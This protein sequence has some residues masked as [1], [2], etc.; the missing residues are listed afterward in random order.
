MQ[1]GELAGA[2]TESPGIAQA[3]KVQVAMEEEGAWK[4]YS[5]IQQK[6]KAD[7][8]DVY[9]YDHGEARSIGQPKHFVGPSGDEICEQA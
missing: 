1:R 2:A 6:A 8:A 7:D 3:Q 4:A 5:G 9:P